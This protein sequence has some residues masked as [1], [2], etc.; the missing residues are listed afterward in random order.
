M[1]SERRTRL[2]KLLS[3]VLRHRPDMMG[4][5]IDPAGWVA[6]DAVLAGFAARGVG[7]TR[8]DLHEIVRTSD[9][10]RFALSDDGA[11]IRANQGHSVDV[12]LGHPVAEPP[13]ELFHGTVAR[14]VDSIR[15]RGLERRGRHHV[16]LSESVET[17]CRVGARRGTPVI[18]R[19]DARRMV[20][21]G[22]VFQRTPNGVWL[23]DH[24][25]A[26]FIEFP[27]AAEPSAPS[28]RDRR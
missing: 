6:I 19:V 27:S 8:D 13:P 25:P 5:A 17:A 9:K 23:T 10:Q 21:R 2:S 22:F 16:H 15:E 26:E 4:L 18:V 11:S 1:D 3:K 24:V 28:G 12:D 20:A 7:L 14:F